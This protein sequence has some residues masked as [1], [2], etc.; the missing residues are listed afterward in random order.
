M[1]QSWNK[2]KIY[3]ICFEDREM[4]WIICRTW[5][6]RGNISIFMESKY[7]FSEQ[8]CGLCWKS[9]TWQIMKGGKHFFSNMFPL[10][11][12]S[13]NN[14][15]QLQYYDFVWAPNRR[16]LLLNVYIF[17]WV[18]SYNRVFIISTSM[19]IARSTPGTYNSFWTVLQGKNH[20]S[21]SR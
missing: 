20:L 2:F 14:I 6:R 8:C 5:H 4:W 17:N 11:H 18:S 21:N 7:C 3:K 10:L 1:W 16:Y 19:Y 13:K 12:I 9:P 15:D